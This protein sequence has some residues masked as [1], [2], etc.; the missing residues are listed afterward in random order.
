MKKK[1]KLGVG[2][3]FLGTL[4]VATL[5]L[6]ADNPSRGIGSCQFSLVSWN[7]SEAPWRFLIF[8][9]RPDYPDGP[10]RSWLLGKQADIVGLQEDFYMDIFDQLQ[11]YYKYGLSPKNGPIVG[12]FVPG[13]P[14]IEPLGSGLSVLVSLKD[15]PY[16]PDIIQLHEGWREWTNCSNSESFDCQAQ[17]GFAYMQ[18]FIPLTTLSGYTFYMPLDYYDL[19]MDAGGTGGDRT[20]RQ[21]QFNQLKSF[22]NQ[23]SQGKSVIIS[24]DFNCHYQDVNDRTMLLSFMNSQNLAFAND[25]AGTDTVDYVLFRSGDPRESIQV[26]SCYVDPT[27]HGLSD[28]DALSGQFNYSAN[29]DAYPDL[30]VEDILSFTYDQYNGWG[31]ATAVVKNK[32]PASASGCG[33]YMTIRAVKRSMGYG[34]C[35]ALDAGESAIVDIGYDTAGGEPIPDYFTYATVIATV[36]RH[37]S[38]MLVG[39]LVRENNEL[40]NTLEKSV[41]VIWTNL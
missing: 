34:N 28:H 20:A 21:N 36:D 35:P 16:K 26:I 31:Y 39:G 40:N 12:D 33:I 30:I 13:I 6:I 7:V 9:Y 32:G 2:V 4:V 15:I 1:L 17:K 10:Q 25:P 24:G 37:S 11:H 23:Y 29:Y 22:M 27:S 19:H 18:L 8:P 14:T 38:D 3:F 41:P 5:T